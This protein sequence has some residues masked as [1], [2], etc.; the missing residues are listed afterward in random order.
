LRKITK[1]RKTLMNLF[2][3]ELPKDEKSSWV[4]LRRV[5]K[6]RKKLM[7]VFWEEL[8]KDEKSSWKFL[9]TVTKG[10]KKLMNVSWEGIR[11]ILTVG[12]KPQI[13]LTKCTSP[14]QRQRS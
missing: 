4:F 7:N 12:I 10:W 8:P 11:T 1:G 14:H 9:R 6:G 2:W 3:E 13:F 5:T